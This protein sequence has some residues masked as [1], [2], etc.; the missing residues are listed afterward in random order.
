MLEL[1]APLVRPAD[2]GDRPAHDGPPGVV[3]VE[4]VADERAHDHA[5]LD[6]VQPLAQLTDE[7]GA[8]AGHDADRELAARA[9]RRSARAS[10]GRR[11]RPPELR[12][13]GDGSGRGTRR[14]P[15]RTARESARR[16]APRAR[17]PP[18]RGRSRRSPPCRRSSTAANSGRSASDGSL[19]R[20]AGAARRRRSRAA[21][22]W[23]SRTTSCRRCRGRRRVRR[24]G[25]RRCASRNA[26]IASRVG[27]GRHD[28][29][30]SL[31]S[32]PVCGL[33]SMDETGSAAGHAQRKPTWLIPVSIIC[34]RRAA[35][36]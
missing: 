27:P 25:R 33:L 20:C 3:A 4:L 19:A 34:G 30:R 11:H 14:P 35:G 31:I 18:W 6:P 16:T 1:G 23:A 36:R 12:A 32:P 17:P 21:R 5:G 29:S 22:R 26:R 10:A 15:R 8:A 7:L 28:G 13:Y 9:A 24:R 2:L